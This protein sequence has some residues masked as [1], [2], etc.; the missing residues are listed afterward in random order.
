M[1][2]ADRIMPDP[3]WEIGKHALMNVRVSLI[4]GR[5]EMQ[6]SS[7][8]IPYQWQGA[9]YQDNDDQPFLLLINSGGGF[10]EGDSASF[11]ATLDPGT[12]ALI[13]TTAASKYYKCPEGRVSRETVSMP[14]AKPTSPDPPPAMMAQL[15]LGQW[16]RPA[17]SLIFGVRPNSPQAITVTSSNM[18]RSSRSSTRALKH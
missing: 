12:R 13:T 14:S 18:P 3:S 16:S 7:W 9:H 15:T 8:R 2:A 6:P 5:S 10:V 11:H 1:A 4:N 17:P